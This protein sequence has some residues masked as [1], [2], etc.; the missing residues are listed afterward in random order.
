[1]AAVRAIGFD[2]DHTLAI[3][4]RL[5]RVALLRLLEVI[6]REGGESVG[7]LAD[8]IDNIDELLK[9]QR[10]GDFSIDDAVRRFIAEHRV[11]PADRYVER[12]RF[13]AAH[14]VDEFVVPLP[15]VAPMLDAIRGRGIAMA[16]LSNGWN[17]LQSRKAERAGFSGTVLVSS[18][19]GVQKP[20]SRAFTRLLEALGTRAEDTW[21]VGDNP[22]GDIAGAQR[23]GMETVWMNWERQTY[24]AELEPPTLTIR[25]FGELLGVLPEAARAR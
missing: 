8:E 7:T 2:L 1:M 24:P 17:P 21:Y 5:E 22:Y 12:F 4:N 19:I 16:V 9:R 18:D 13:D 6:L 3:D 11:Q 23:I 15:G 20:D 14:M 10:R 25:G